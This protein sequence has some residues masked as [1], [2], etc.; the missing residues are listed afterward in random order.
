MPISVVARYLPRRSSGI[1]CTLVHGATVRSQ[2]TNDPS[3]CLAEAN[4]GCKK[5]SSLFLRF[6][7]SLRRLC[8]AFMT[9]STFGWEKK[10]FPGNVHRPTCRFRFDS[11]LRSLPAH[12]L[13]FLFN[14]ADF[15]RRCSREINCS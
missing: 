6:R 13:V 8:R 11:L 4:I 9:L 2:K 5:R 15:F 7:E 3:N 14:S 1:I 12:P 10:R